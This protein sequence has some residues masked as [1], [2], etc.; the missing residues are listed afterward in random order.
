MEPAT[1][2]KQAFDKLPI[3]TVITTI[4][5]LLEEGRCKFENVFHRNGKFRGFTGEFSDDRRAAIE[6]LELT[7]MEALWRRRRASIRRVFKRG[8]RCKRM[9]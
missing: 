7:R 4:V 1:E 2:T 6:K 8:R 3:S 5:K 9:V